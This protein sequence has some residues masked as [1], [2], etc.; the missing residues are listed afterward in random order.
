MNAPKQQGD[1]S[2]KLYQRMGGGH[3]PH[4]YTPDHGGLSSR[5]DVKGKC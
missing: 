4:L 2:K 3:G 1:I 5:P